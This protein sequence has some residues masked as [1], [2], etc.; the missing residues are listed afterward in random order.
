MIAPGGGS[1]GVSRN[2]ESEAK[3]FVT[4]YEELITQGTAD[5]VGPS[6]GDVPDECYR[7]GLEANGA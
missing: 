3:V 2:G 1:A 4:G 5:V 6:E 7:F